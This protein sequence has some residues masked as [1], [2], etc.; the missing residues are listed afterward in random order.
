MGYLPQCKN[1][2]FISYRHA[3]NASNN[4]WVDEF[5]KELRSSLEERVGQV[6]IWRDSAEIRAGDQWRKEIDEALDTAAIFLAIVVTTYF[7]SPVCAA[8]LDRFLARMKGP[9]GVIQPLLVPIYKLLPEP[10]QVPPELKAAHY[11]QFFDP[12]PYSEFFPGDEKTTHRFYEAL[13]RLALD[14]SIQLARLRGSTRDNM[15]GTVYLAEVG[16]ELYPEREKLR[17]DLLQRG[18]WVIPEHPYLWNASDFDRKIAGDLDSAQ[19]CI[20][21]LGR[22]GSEPE[23][24]KQAKLQ[25]ERATAAMK[26]KG[27]PPPMVWVQ[28]AK[29]TDALA[30]SLIDYIEQDL[31]NEGVEYWQ[32]SREDFKTQ[33]YD[34]LSRRLTSP[35]VTKKPQQ[36]ALIVEESDI[37][38]TGELNDVLVNNLKHDSKRIKFSGSHPKD[39]SSLV[40]VLDS[41][42]QCIIF[43]GAQ[44][45]EWL[46]DI[47]AL[48]AMA[49][50]LGKE[51][52][53]VYVSAPATPEKNTF[54]TNKARMIQATSTV[55]ETE[56]G[57]FLAER[58]IAP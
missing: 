14:L 26:L 40:K 27:K 58:L 43:W 41:C 3:S 38:T 16:P 36:I 15:V 50:Y 6:S 42:S 28:P 8:E 35:Q 20:H 55:N 29:Q 21:I 13:S 10:D 45:E 56:L 39:P 33:I 37:A 46:S 44:S 24:Y 22:T 1:D 5:H 52:L 25:L 30:G 53:C 12:N 2:I 32:G 4:K 18:Y 19:L 51:R 9:K 48:D 11:H 31:A 17:S 34:Q 57:N 47:L 23:S 49:D 54:R 7:E